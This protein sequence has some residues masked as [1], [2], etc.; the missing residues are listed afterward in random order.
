MLGARLELRLLGLQL[1][2]LNRLI[3]FLDAFPSLEISLL[4]NTLNLLSTRGRGI[5]NPHRLG[6]WEA[7]A[8][9]GGVSGQEPREPGVPALTPA[10]IT[11]SPHTL[12][13]SFLEVLTVH[14]VSRVLGQ[15]LKSGAGG[16]AL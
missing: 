2:G 16:C 8:V 14:K 1:S 13:I 6:A 9:T 5:S 7:E 11:G 4:W 10:F 15:I 12:S 3:T